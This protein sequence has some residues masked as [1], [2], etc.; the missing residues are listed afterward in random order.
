[1]V[2]SGMLCHMALVTLMKEA[3]S[4]SYMS[5]LTRATRYN[6]PEDAILHSHR[7]ENLKSYIINMLFLYYGLKIVLCI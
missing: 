2:S 1:M 7:H 4:S 6:I 5:V 3:L